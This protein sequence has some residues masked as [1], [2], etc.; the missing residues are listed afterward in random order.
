VVCETA[1]VPK[2]II[3]A[4]YNQPIF[5]GFHAIV[6]ILGHES[7]AKKSPQFRLIFLINREC[8]VR[9]RTFEQYIISVIAVFSGAWIDKEREAFRAKNN[10]E[11][12]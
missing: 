12:I 9:Y 7:P 6:Y 11:D 8:I 2:T 4:P 3:P 5:C 1:D 10:T